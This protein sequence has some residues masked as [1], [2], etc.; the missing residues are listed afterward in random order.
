[1]SDVVLRVGGYAPPDSSHSS[2]LGVFA[3]AVR[4]ESDGRIDVEI[5]GNVLELGRPAVSLLEM[6]ESGELTLCYFSTSYLGSRVPA[7]NV[8]ETPFLFE[9]LDQAHDALD[10]ELGS[11]LTAATEAATPFV[12]LGYWDNGFRHMTNRLRAVRSPGDVAGMRIRLQPNRLHAAM[13]EAW[14]GVP[15]PVELSRGIQ[16]IRNGEVDAQE[17]PLANTVAYGVNDVHGFATMTAHLY[18][19]RGVYAHSGSLASLAVDDQEIVRRAVAEAISHQRS[20]AA[21]K[22]LECRTLMTRQGVSFVDPSPDERNQF[23][24]AVSNVVEGARATHG[25]GLYDLIPRS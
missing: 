24:E 16:M 6:V 7:L 15:V 12:V 5:L 19:A 23:V 14:G 17:N 1:M 8:L 21:D 3:D 18:G 25:A 20:A 22:E 11:A 9:N 2:A 4:R 13:I 10:G